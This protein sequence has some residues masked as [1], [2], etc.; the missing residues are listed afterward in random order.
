MTIRDTDVRRERFDVRYWHLA[1]IATGSEHVR[2]RGGS[3]RR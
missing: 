3:G 2:F 1:D